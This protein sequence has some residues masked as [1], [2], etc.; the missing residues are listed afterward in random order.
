MATNVTHPEGPWTDSK[1]S[2]LRALWAGGLRTVAIGVELGVSKNAVVGKAHRLGLT[3]RPSPIKSGEGFKPARV[4]RL[5]PP[6]LAEILSLTAVAAM[7]ASAART[8]P[9]FAPHRAPQVTN[10]AIATRY[11]ITERPRLNGGINSC[12][13]PIGHPGTSAFR[14]CELAC[15]PAKP[16]CDAHAARAYVP[17]P[18]TRNNGNRL[19]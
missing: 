11:A 15:L 9:A 18:P 6:K 3:A 10:D 1:V 14:F 7:P 8:R 5:R 17:P 16:Y 2:R 4:P 19:V 13:W 12:C